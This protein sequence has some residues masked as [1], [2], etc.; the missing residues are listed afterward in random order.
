MSIFDTI[1]DMGAG[2]VKHMREVPH[3]QRAHTTIDRREIAAMCGGCDATI[4]NWAERC[5]MPQP[6]GKVTRGVMTQWDTQV[7][8]DWFMSEKGKAI[9]AAAQMYGPKRKS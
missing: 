5:I 4:G 6:I 7:F 8:M 2:L 1:K 3:D 9:I